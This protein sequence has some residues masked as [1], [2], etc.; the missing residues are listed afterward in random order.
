MGIT[1]KSVLDEAMLHSA[2]AAGGSPPP[3]QDRARSRS[4]PLRNISVPKPRHDVMDPRKI[5]YIQDSIANI[6]RCRRM[7][8]DT[9]EKLRRRDIS[10]FDDIPPIRVFEWRGM[11]FTSDNRRLWAFKT[12]RVAEVPVV[13]TMASQVDPDKFTTRNDGTSIR[14]RG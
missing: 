9:M 6:F 3:A 11:I 10:P 13:R 14:M 7:V 8:R 1:Y 12:A 2:D 5:R 4:S